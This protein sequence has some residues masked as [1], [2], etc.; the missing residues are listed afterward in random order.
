MSKRGTL[1]S[2]FLK[3]RVPNATLLLPLFGW[4]LLGALAPRAV[5][6][7]AERPNVVFIMLDDMGPADVG[8]YGSKV[9]QT[10]N[11]DRMAADGI[12]FTQAY[13]GCSVCAPTRG[14]LMT[15]RHMG[16]ATVRA[17]PG[18]VPLRDEDV[19]IAEVLKKAGYATG[20]FGKWGLGDLDTPGVPERQGFDRFFGYYHQ[21]HAHRFY[22]DYLIDTGKK[23]PLPTNAGFYGPGKRPEGPVDTRD[24][25]TGEQHVFS[26]YPI[27]EEMK[28]FI[29]ANRDRPFFC[30]APWTIPHMRY[31]IPA[32]DPA[33]QTYKDQPWSTAEKGHA[34]YCSLADRFVGETLTLLKELGI[35]DRTVVFFCSDNGAPNRSAILHSSGGL[36]GEKGQLYEGGIR[37][38]LI[39]R[40]PGRIKPG[41]VSDTP[42]YLPDVLPTLAELA[43]A[44]P[45]LPPG[46][47]GVSLAPELLGT[48]RLPRD[49]PL[50]WEWN[51][52]HFAPYEPKFQAVRRGR[53]KIVRHALDGP[54]ELFDLEGDPGETRDV[55]AGHPQVVTEL[56]AWVAQ[57]REPH[58]PQVEPEKPPGQR[59]R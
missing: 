20:G 56:S 22:P 24:P 9:I 47:D 35:D 26:A 18:G 17:N 38:P 44:T 1:G 50:Y 49:R 34:A 4:L 41:G 59:W 3:T 39:V 11:L 42:V 28:A 10:P 12:R 31:E 30:Y 48:G 43:G 14:A 58:G 27:F 23:V 33:W 19:T 8:R 29:R 36:R 40:W 55:A 51:G 57:N 52:E 32:S 2:R 46:V 16:H 37:T 13:A 54:W 45:G 5:A 6:A 7:D 15:G 53:W 25:K 21:V